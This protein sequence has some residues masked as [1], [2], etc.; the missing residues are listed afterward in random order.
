M[1]VCLFD[2]LTRIESRSKNRKERNEPDWTRYY[3]CAPSISDRSMTNSV[4]PETL[5]AC[6]KANP[7]V[8]H[9]MANNRSTRPANRLPHLA[10]V[11]TQTGNFSETNDEHVFFIN[12]RTVRK[13]SMIDWQKVKNVK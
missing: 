8:R 13:L 11:S 7:I 9:L 1:I 2:R 5:S 10:T 12:R 4:N 3:K 6:L